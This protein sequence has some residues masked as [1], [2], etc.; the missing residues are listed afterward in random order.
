VYALRTRRRG[1]A[2]LPTVDDTTSAGTSLAMTDVVAGH[3]ARNP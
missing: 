2:R 1:V 3:W